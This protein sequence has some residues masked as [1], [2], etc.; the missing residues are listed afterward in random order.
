MYAYVSISI[1]I[2]IFISISIYVHMYIYIRTSDGKLVDNFSHEQDV[3][4]LQTP[5]TS[6]L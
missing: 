2:S 6:R 5:S 3:R 1:S 4:S